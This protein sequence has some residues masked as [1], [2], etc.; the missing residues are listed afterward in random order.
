MAQK[1]VYLT[2]QGL[3]RMEAELQTLLS[4]RRPD[5]AAKIQRAKE[6]GGTDNNAEYEEA[7]NE[8]AFIEG[9][10]MR[11]EQMIQRAK[12][13]PNECQKAGAV[14]LGCTVKVRHPDGSQEQYTIVGKEEADPTNGRISNESPVGKALMG[15][16]KG[17]TVEVPVPAGKIKL[18]ILE[19]S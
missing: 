4:V 7:K 15:K 3:S 17:E 16:K 9:H 19:V 18:K 2:Q 12:L 11:L 14:T 13:I 5:V 6:L 1:E 8:Q 10:I